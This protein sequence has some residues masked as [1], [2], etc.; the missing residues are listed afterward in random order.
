MSASPRVLFLGLDAADPSLV[1]RWA[2]AGQLPTF[3][4]LLGR[5]RTC[6][7]LGPAGFFVG[8]IWPSFYT[9]VNPARH[10]C[11]CWEQLEVGTYDVR[12]F[13]AGQN[14]AREAFWETLSRAGRRVGIVDVP[15]SGPATTLNGLQV[16]EWGCH[17]P[18]L[19]FSARPIDLERHFVARFGIHPVQ[20]NCN[21]RG[22]SVEETLRFR[23]DL[24]HGAGMKTALNLTLLREQRW[25]LF[26]SVY[27]EAHCIGHQAWHVHDASHPLHDPELARATGDPILAVYRALDRGVGHILS[28]VDPGTTTFVWLSHGMGPK[29]FPTFAL[30]DYLRRVEAAWGTAPADAPRARRLFFQ[31]SNNYVEAGIRI[32]LLG[33][34]PEGRVAPGAEFDAVVARLEAELATLVDADRGT[35][36]VRALV[37][38]RKLYSGELVDRLPDLFVQWNIEGPVRCLSSP[39]A[40]EL[41]LRPFSPRTG[42]HG[43]EGLV[44]M[45]GPGLGRDSLAEPI[46]VMDFAPTIAGLLGVELPD[47]EGRVIPGVVG[48]GRP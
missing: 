2:A 45:L 28:G 41:L 29:Y 6:R 9:S 25:D 47:V 3:A 18:D 37:Q 7:T 26:L 23:D 27:S 40:G 22:R 48:G 34:E 5:A 10:G 43:P 8:A 17:D 31:H 30:D 35:P 11:H 20:G 21:F 44:L 24:V 36:L 32:N 13:R 33:R 16:I 38:T 14:Q 46:D 1:R 42:D 15:L 4:D 19:G 12:R 39:A